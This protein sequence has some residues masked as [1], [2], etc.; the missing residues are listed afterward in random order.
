[1]ITI[2]AFYENDDSHYLRFALFT[3]VRDGKGVLC[4][5]CG[6]TNKRVDQVP[7]GALHLPFLKTRQTVLRLD[8]EGFVFDS[9]NFEESDL[10]FVADPVN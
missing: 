2:H 4:W 9:K 5:A 7:E 10:L 8:S 1:M 3:L 6:V